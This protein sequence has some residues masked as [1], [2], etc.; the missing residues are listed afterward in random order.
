QE[1]Q[2]FT[3]TLNST[4]LPDTLFQ[5]E[6]RFHHNADS[7]VGH[8]YVNLDVVG[9]MDPFPFDLVH[10]ANGDAITALPL[11][12]DTLNVPAIRFIWR[13]AR[14]PNRADSLLTYRLNINVL[15]RAW[16][17]TIERDTFFVVNLDTLGLPLW[18]DRPVNW[19][20]SVRSGENGA[21]GSANCVMPF[22]FWIAQNA[23]DKDRQP[24]AREFA[25]KSAYPNP[26]N[27]QTV[28]RYALDRD[29]CARLAAF[30]IAGREVMQLMQGDAQAGPHSLIWNA[31]S[32]PTGV[33]LLR[34]ESA[35]R[36]KTMKAAIIK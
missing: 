16:T 12:G 34:L 36:T 4:G 20:A 25:L 11:H 33:Y 14:D 1:V 31:E 27:M 5:G 8:I 18:F 32:L 28:V 29:G 21:G 19:S 22:S 10:P 24:A 17:T 30:D 7:S 26:F 35:G 2:D 15:E 3:L 6:L 23:L 13:K 9:V